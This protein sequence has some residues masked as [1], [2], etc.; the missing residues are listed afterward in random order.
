MAKYFGTDGIRGRYGI[1]LNNS[2]AFKL[3]QSLKSVLG[4]ER[5][6]IGMDTRESGSSLLKFKLLSCDIRKASC[7]CNV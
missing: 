3:G 1:E 2:I 7:V 4:T 6:V 5:L